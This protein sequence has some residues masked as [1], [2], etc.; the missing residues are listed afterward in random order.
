MSQIVSNE[1]LNRGKKIE[2][3]LNSLY[4]E[5]WYSKIRR[6]E[7]QEKDEESEL[8]IC[9]YC[10]Q[11]LERSYWESRYNGMKAKCKACEV[12]WNVS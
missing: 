7:K 2:E 9:P 3:Y 11:Q 4:L 10:D 1:R 8:D 6:S 12:I 5:P